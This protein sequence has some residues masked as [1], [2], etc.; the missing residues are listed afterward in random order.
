M[1][2]A[3]PVLTVRSVDQAVDWYCNFLGF[4]ADYL[5]AES[6]EEN[7]LNYAVL[8]NGDARIHLGLEME[9]GVL[10]GHG[11]CNFVT[12]HFDRFHEM[13]VRADATF[14]VQLGEIPTG[15]RTFGIKDP[16]GNLLTFIEAN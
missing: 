1:E 4:T 8:R 11:G 3:Q 7:S 6:D 9:M 12:H 14:H 5:N 16:D 2:S 10:S 15:T 13:A